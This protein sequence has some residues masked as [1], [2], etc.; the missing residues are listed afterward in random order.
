[1]KYC[2][3]CGSSL[4]DNNIF[5]PF[6]GKKQD[7]KIIN[8]NTQLNNKDV[9]DDKIITIKQEISISSKEI[10]NS[11]KDNSPKFKLA[12]TI[13]ATVF[14]CILG[15]VFILSIESPNSFPYR[16]L[17]F[18]S[19]IIFSCLFLPFSIIGFVSALRS[20]SVSGIVWTS[21]LLS[22]YIAIVAIS[23]NGGF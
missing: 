5:C 18:L 10:N 2:I 15:F 11:K 17:P 6:C 16:D 4:E 3:N 13:T 20:K 12:Q 1:M 8:N 19:T 7:I 23:I 9:N 22:T 21:I 14:W